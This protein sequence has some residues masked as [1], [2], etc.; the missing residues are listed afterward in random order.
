MIGADLTRWKGFLR[1]PVILIGDI[2]Y[3]FTDRSNLIIY[4]H[5]LLL[6]IIYY[7]VGT[8]YEGGHFY[9]DISIPQDYPY[10]APKVE[11]LLHPVILFK[12]I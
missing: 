11:M 10:T 5:L 2:F 3:F 1:G 12:Q 4:Y 7:Q 6:F 9:L 8:P